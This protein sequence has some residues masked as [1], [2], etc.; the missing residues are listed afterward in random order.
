MFHVV[1]PEPDLVEESRLLT[2]CSWHEDCGQRLGLWK[3]GCPCVFG[4]GGVGAT[5]DHDT[6]GS[7]TPGYDGV[8]LAAVLAGLCVELESCHCI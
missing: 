6:I 7:V 3:P 4:G 8:I 5:T 1:E 2:Y